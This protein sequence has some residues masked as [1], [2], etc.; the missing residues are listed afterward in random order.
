MVIDLHH[1][2]ADG[3]KNSP[4]LRRTWL[5][6]LANKH[7]LSGRHA[8]AAQCYLHT[9]ALVAEYKILVEPKEYLPQGCAAFGHISPNVEEESATSD[10]IGD[11]SA[12]VSLS[13][14]SRWR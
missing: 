8:E 4:D 9:V 2:I 6:N 5:V 11:P 7:A 3:Y 1:R 13:G 14:E 12:E 10:D